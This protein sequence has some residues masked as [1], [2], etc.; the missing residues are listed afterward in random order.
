MDRPKGTMGDF[1]KLAVNLGWRLAG[2][3]RG[4]MGRCCR[5]C[6]ITGWGGVDGM[7]GYGSSTGAVHGE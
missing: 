7:L 4:G 2:A 3:K 6:Y 5:V 1:S